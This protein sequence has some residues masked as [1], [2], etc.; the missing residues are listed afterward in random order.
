MSRS[1]K[2]WL[3]N[4]EL[5]RS[6]LAKGRGWEAHVARELSASGLSVRV[7]DCD[8]DSIECKKE[9]RKAAIDSVDLYVNDLVIEVKSR[10]YLFTCSDDFPFQTVAIDTKDGFKK[11][12]IKPDV[13]ISVCQKNGCMI[14]LDVFGTRSEWVVSKRFDTVRRISVTSYDCCKSLW[15]DDVAQLIRDLSP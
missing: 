7:P 6:E 8:L 14:A 1:A 11:R 10:N 12:A 15:H 9:R 4:D 5:F 3:E 2:R 13:Y